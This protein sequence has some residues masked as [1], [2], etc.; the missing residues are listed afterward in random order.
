M[1]PSALSKYVLYISFTFSAKRKSEQT[2]IRVLGGLISAYELT[3]QDPIL[4]EKAIDLAD[5]ILP[6]FET[7]SGLPF[8]LV[9]LAERKG[10]HT[11]DFP[12]L[13]SIAEVG[14]L[15]LEFKYLSEITDNPIYKR[16]VKHVRAP[17]GEVLKLL[18][19]S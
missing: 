1:V 5:R 12:G 10:Y 17:S 7:T 13:V 4:L 8:P 16:K 19:I 6:A 2:T 3:A 11:T 18:M 15:Q 9:N 14:T